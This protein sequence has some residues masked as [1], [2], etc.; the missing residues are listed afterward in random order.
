LVTTAIGPPRRYPAWRRESAE[1]AR[2]GQVVELLD[3]LLHAV[4]HEDDEAA[5]QRAGVTGAAAAAEADL[6]MQVVADDG[7][8]H[9][10]VA[11]Y[12]RGAQEG[13]GVQAPVGHVAEG[14]H[15]AGV[16]VGEGHH[17]RV[18]DGHRQLFERGPDAA[19]LEEDVSVWGVDALGDRGGQHGYAGAGEQHI[20]VLDEAPGGDGHHLARG[21]GG[22]GRLCV[23]HLIHLRSRPGA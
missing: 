16:Q 18:G 4:L 2:R 14:F 17:P 8:V 23:G 11:V 3:K 20:T 19:G 5:G 13:D 21:V 6:R 10:A 15:E 22:H 12:L 7:G 1:P 9:V